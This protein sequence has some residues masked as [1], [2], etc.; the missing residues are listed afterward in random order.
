MSSA[1][2]VAGCEPMHSNKKH[3]VCFVGRECHKDRRPM[4]CVSDMARWQ[5]VVLE[6][7]VCEPKQCRQRPQSPRSHARQDVAPGAQ[8]PAVPRTPPHTAFS[9]P[10]SGAVSVIL[11]HFSPQSL[12]AV[13]PTEPSAVRRRRLCWTR[14]AGSC[15]SPI[16]AGNGFIS[17]LPCLYSRLDRFASW[18][19]RMD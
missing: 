4:I 18:R 7:K 16:V 6:P 2:S 3:L 12:S 5:A 8:S 11:T 10:Q 14:S 1:S 13:K 15:G 17:C 9:S 19:R